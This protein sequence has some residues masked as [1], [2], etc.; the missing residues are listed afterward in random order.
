MEQNFLIMI[1][2]KID[3]IELYPEMYSSPCLYGT[4]NC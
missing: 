3:V 4:D 2:R 1:E